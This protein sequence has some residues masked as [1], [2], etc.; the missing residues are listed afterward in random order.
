MK[1]ILITVIAFS[2]LLT[3]CT[4][5][6][7][8]VDN[9]EESTVPEIVTTSAALPDETEEPIET[10]EQTV[11][12]VE[13]PDLSP[14]ALPNIVNGRYGYYQLNNDE[15]E[16]YDAV[17]EAAMAFRSEVELPKKL[18]YEAVK[19]L[20]ETLAIEVTDLYYLSDQYDCT[21][22]EVTG[23]VSKISLT[24]K[25]NS[26]TVENINKELERKAVKILSTANGL[27]KYDK[28]K[29]FHDVIITNCDYSDESDYRATPYGAL[30][31]GKA[32]CEGYARAFAY[33]CNK[34]GIENL[35]ATGIVNG[36]EHMWN[37]VKLDGSWYNIDLTRDDPIGLPAELKS[38]Q[39]EYVSYNYFLIKNTQF[40]GNA[41]YSDLYN[42][43]QTNS[44]KYNYYRYN[45]LYAEDYGQAKHIL[46]REIYAAAEDKR[47]FVEIMLENKEL[48]EETVF[49]LFDQSK[50]E[51]F[52]AN[53]TPNDN[54]VSTYYLIPSDEQNS[55]QVVLIYN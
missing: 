46:G 27:S 22:N 8:V 2:L 17:Y 36:C 44:D 19:K 26:L 39:K 3:A 45:D 14:S 49:N 29:Y 33:L 30:V 52:E 54:S 4:R 38:V 16:N 25:F 35:L 9:V 5:E 43:P 6:E 37:M 32:W 13:N 12:S 34:S 21:M 48:Y 53:V 40:G 50:K 51:F 23:I 1:R 47:V 10:A 15:K 7:P 18:P 41:K 24:Y 55:F 11:V 28:M 20:I 42:L 31:V